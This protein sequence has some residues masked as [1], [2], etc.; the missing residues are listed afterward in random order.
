M[1]TYNNFFPIIELVLFPV[2]LTEL[3]F[4]FNLLKESE[5]FSLTL[6]LL[7]IKPLFTLFFWAELFF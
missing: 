4:V 7:F 6:F 2:E 5:I 3:H 1:F